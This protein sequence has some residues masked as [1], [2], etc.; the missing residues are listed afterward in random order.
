MRQGL[1]SP[2]DIDVAAMDTAQ[3]LGTLAG[4]YAVV[5]GPAVLSRRSRFA[6]VLQRPLTTTF[7]ELTRARF[8]GVRLTGVGVRLVGVIGDS[9]VRV[10]L[11]DVSIALTWVK[12]AVVAAGLNSLASVRTG[13]VIDRPGRAGRIVS[14]A[15]RA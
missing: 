6:I 5:T 9:G 12:G 3:V 11:I 8:V 14:A 15:P 13:A 4:E 10:E 1:T 2:T 7:V